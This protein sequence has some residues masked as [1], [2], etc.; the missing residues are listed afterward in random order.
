M[1]PS[2]F[3]LTLDPLV[4]KNGNT[5]ETR[6]M[7]S[8]FKYYCITESTACLFFAILMRALNRINRARAKTLFNHPKKHFCLNLRGFLYFCFTHCREKI[9]TPDLGLSLMYNCSLR[10]KR[11]RRVWEQKNRGTGFSVFCLRGKWGES[12]KKGG[13]GRGGEGR[14]RLQI[15]PC[16]LKTPFA[17]ERGSWLA[18]LVEHF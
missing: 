8:F 2:P 16:I 7:F 1:F 12:Q 6:Y 5:I 10:S 13:G 3:S 15:N 11:F 17:G 4:T 18:G 9:R 14:N